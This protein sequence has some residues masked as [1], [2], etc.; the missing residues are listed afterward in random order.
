MTK[1]EWGGEKIQY[2]ISI[3]THNHKVDAQTPNLKS[4]RKIYQTSQRPYIVGYIVGKL[5]I[6]VVNQPP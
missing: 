2:L 1:G 6:C 4:R 5:R 3:E